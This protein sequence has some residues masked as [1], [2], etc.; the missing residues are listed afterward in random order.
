METTTKLTL[1][2]DLDCGERLF[3]T[4]GEMLQY[5]SEDATENQTDHDRRGSVGL[6][7]ETGDPVGSDYFSFDIYVGPDSVSGYDDYY[8]AFVMPSIAKKI[9]EYVEQNKQYLKEV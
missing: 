8:E 4:L 6:F 7:D 2:F 9:N 3:Y 1:K 5:V